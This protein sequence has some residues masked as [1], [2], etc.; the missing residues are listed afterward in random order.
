MSTC[1]NCGGPCFAVDICEAC[2]LQW[3]EHQEHLR[4]LEEQQMQEEL[5]RQDETPDP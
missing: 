3:Y 1:G 5:E 2:E 4:W